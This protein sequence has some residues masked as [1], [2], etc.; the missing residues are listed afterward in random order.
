LNRVPL[1]KASREGKEVEPRCTRIVGALSA[2]LALAEAAAFIDH[3]V[4]AGFV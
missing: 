2:P 4:I 1:I 3:G